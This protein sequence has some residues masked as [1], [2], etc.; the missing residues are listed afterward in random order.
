MINIRV[1]F[2]FLRNF[3][4]DNLILKHSK[5][6]YGLSYSQTANLESSSYKLLNIFKVLNVVDT[7]LDQIENNEVYLLI[8][9]IF[10]LIFI[11]LIRRIGTFVLKLSISFT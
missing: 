3:I 4:F 1:L 6:M 5:S 2:T 7:C 11:L 9:K 8:L 10:G